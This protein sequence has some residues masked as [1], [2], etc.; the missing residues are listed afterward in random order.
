MQHLDFI[1]LNE[2]DIIVDKNCNFNLE[3]TVSGFEIYSA[4]RVHTVRGDK[5]S[6][7]KQMDKIRYI[8][9]YIKIDDCM[10]RVFNMYGQFNPT[11]TRAKSEAII[12]Q[13]DAVKKSIEDMFTMIN[14]SENS[15]KVLIK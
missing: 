11:V 10:V 1:I 15:M 2:K 14:D 7:T 4:D 5:V 8:P 3:T 12:P 6:M 9:L 13:I